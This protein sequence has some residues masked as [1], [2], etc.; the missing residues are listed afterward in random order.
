M[1]HLRFK[2]AIVV[3]TLLFLV[4]GFAAKV[5]QAEP[6]AVFGLP[7]MDAIKYLGDGFNTVQKDYVYGN[8][9]LEF[10]NGALV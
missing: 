10:P 6:K 9:A 4:N 2:L 8:L 3:L 7:D 5:T 1:N